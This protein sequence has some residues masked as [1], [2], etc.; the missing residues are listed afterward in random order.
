M[1]LKLCNYAPFI[2]PEFSMNKSAILEN[3]ALARALPAAV[4]KLSEQLDHADPMIRNRAATAI[5]NCSHRLKAHELETRLKALESATGGQRLRPVS[6]TS[7]ANEN[8]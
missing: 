8:P 6:L 7:G 4:A 5:L 2:Q 1:I 3:V